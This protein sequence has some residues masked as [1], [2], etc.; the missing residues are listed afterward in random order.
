MDALQV[1]EAKTKAAELLD[2]LKSPLTTFKRKK[3][4]VTAIMDKNPGPFVIVCRILLEGVI[5]P[6]DQR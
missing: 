4:I 1:L 5:S 6:K 2:E 3:E